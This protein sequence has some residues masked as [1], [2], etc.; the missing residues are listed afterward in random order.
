MQTAQIGSSTSLT[1]Q[2][3]ELTTFNNR[4]A[5]YRMQ[6]L[7]TANE[8]SAAG[9]SAGLIKSVAFD[10]SSVGD[11]ATNANFT[12]KIGTTALSALTDYVSSTGFTTVFPAATYTHAIGQNTIT[13]STPF[14]WNGTSNIIVEV[15]HSGI[16]AT[17]NA[18]SY[19]TSTTG[20]TV[21]YGFN[22]A[23]TG[24]LSTN[25]FNTTFVVDA[26][27]AATAY[28]WSDG[29]TTVG[30]SNPL[31]VVPTSTTSY[32]ATATANGCPI[33]SNT[34]TVTVNTL[35]AGPSATNS[36]QCGTQVPL[37]SVA[38]TAGAAGTGTFNWYA[39][40]TGGAALQSG[41][42][43]TYSTAVASTTTFYVSE[44]GTNGCESIRT[45]VT[46]T[47]GS[48]PVVAVTGPQTVCNNGIAQLNVTSTISDFDSYVWSPVANLF[49]DAAATVPYTG[50]SATTVYV[51]SAN[52]GA[53][54]FTVS[55]SNSI[56]SCANVASSTV[57]VLPATISATAAGSSF[58]LTGSTVL[59]ASPSTGLG[60]ATL[61]WQ[62]SSDNSTFTDL[63]GQTAATY[64]T[65]VLTSTT[66]YQVQIKNG[67]SVCVTSPSVAVIINNP[68]IVSTAPAAR[69]GTGTV[70]LGA[71]GSAGTTLNWYAAST[72]GAPLATGNSFTTPS[73]SASANYYVSAEISGNGAATV[74]AG[75]STTV[76]SGFSDD[77]ISPFG[78]YFGGMKG[79]FLIK[80][81][82]LYAAGLRAGNITSVTFDVVSGG[83][84]YKG[85]NMSIGSTALNA[86]TTTPVGGLTN[87]YSTTSPAGLTTPASGP[88]AINFSA[89]Y[90]WD[91]TSNIV[92]ETCWSNN[93]TGGTGT[94]V[95]YDATSYVSRNYYRDDSETPATIC[96]ATTMDGTLSSRP[97]MTFAGIAATC[98][99]S[100]STVTATVN[101]AP[102]ITVS[103]TPATICAGES[104]VLNVTSANSGYTYTWTPGSL[105]GASQ[106][107]SP[108]GTATYSVSASDNSGGANDGCTADGTVTVNV[109]PL[110]S[111]TTAT[112]TP[113]TICSGGSSQL[114]V[115]GYTPR[116]YCTPAMTSASATGDYIKSFTFG[117]ISNLNTPDAASDYT[118]YSG[119][120]ANVTAG[121]PVN[122][123][124]M[125]G[126]TSSTYA[127]QFRIWIDLNQ[128]GTFEATESVFNT[129][130]A[131]YSPTV[132]SGS[133]TIPV[134]AYNGITR[135]RVE[136]RYNTTPGTGEGCAGGSQWGE[137]ED[138]NVN[139][140]GGTS[141]PGFTYSWTPA[142]FLSDASIANPMATNATGT[143][144]YTVSVTASG[145]S[146]TQTIT[147]NV[148]PL[149]AINVASDD[150]DN[151]VCAG[152]S[153]M[154]T[155]SG[156]DTYVWSDGV[157]NATAFTPS[158]THTYTVTGTD[159]N[160]C[161]NTATATV[162]V[163][164]LPTVMA[165]SDD[166]NNA[167]CV[168]SSV[169]L[170]GMGATTYSWTSGFTNGI[171]NGIAFNP[172]AT[173][174]YTV[175]GTD[176]NGCT[177]TSSVT[178][179]VN[180]L[181]TVMAMSDDAN[182]AICIGSSLSLTGMGATSYDWTSG[183]TSG[184]TDGTAFT[185]S[186]TD[187]YTVTGTDA[188]GCTNTSTITV[189]VNALPA[190]TA[191]SD[192]AD[193]TICSGANVTLTGM[194]ASS[195]TWTGATAV[196]DNSPFTP[197]ATDT[198][199]VTGTDANGCMNTATITVTVN[200]A[201]T[202]TASSDDADNTVCAGTS[203]TLTGGG[204][205][206][207][208]WTGAT[209]VTNNTPFTPTATD[210]YTV[211]GTAANSCTNT[212]TI[213]ITVNSVPVVSLGADLTQCGSVILDAQNV[214]STYMWSDM[215]TAQTLNVT[216]SGTYFVTVN[217]GSC[218]ATDTINVTL[219]ALPSVTMTPFGA[220]V[221]DNGGPITLSGGLPAGGVY[222]G[223]SVTGGMFDPTGLAGAYL[224]T[225]I[226]TDS[227]TCT[228][229]DTATIMVDV[230]NGIAS[231]VSSDMNISVYP[232]PTDGIFTINITNAKFTKFSVSI[233]DIQGKEVYKDV[234]K[235]SST[236]YSKQ[237]DLEGFAKGVYY[238][239]MYTDSN[240]KIDKLVIH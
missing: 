160:G 216:S 198:Y 97:K 91:G 206:S 212:A 197:S 38:S 220:P 125:A 189:T 120:T 123:T 239:K 105:V 199:T 196:T 85:F 81:S 218:S 170:S 72:G 167:I 77:K 89:P 180:A 10:I 100:R 5:S 192:D 52:A 209:A 99:S 219:H 237:I 36:S 71:T 12:V 224:I 233:V 90:N 163:N 175:T 172:S 62:S 152:T 102:V 113:S 138:Y 127:E 54:T 19:Y 107:V 221:C 67:T 21:A 94:T 68:T 50:T 232:N 55:A 168:G 161:T 213:M 78:H 162:T 31:S 41:T 174:T 178:V 121:N 222:S 39:A 234:E 230:C 131:T 65:P 210:T 157:I 208:T 147:L 93:N 139:I 111:L 27:P 2:T 57:T 86:L 26:T 58:C 3:G 53:S 227:N 64:T 225:Y 238:I 150:A 151:T 143:T 32:V 103:A 191:M 165:M 156:A 126:G 76:S 66:Y 133:A 128:N 75:A 51:S 61:Q 203:V 87:V 20:N 40:S 185:P 204:A 9:L 217:N 45:P 17:N 96:G 43:T 1:T 29:S 164:P 194:G 211:T 33:T 166:A 144:T 4:R 11:A 79:Q 188:N 179:T 112:A 228:N 37:A 73:I 106:T 109:T 135:M 171:T 231:A 116:T 187:T 108:S 48:A 158:S 70:A 122:L 8:L 141:N 181:P 69:C 193:N 110:P 101:T 137:Y 184:I 47:V 34:V 169:T 176:A 142:T 13:F 115:A 92:I 205:V 190:V 201:P 23:T 28:S 240:L 145:C 236:V 202:V 207:Y 124:L 154:L 84:L 14:T 159:L 63:T 146:A 130:T 95:R 88:L 44:T 60:A 18:Q 82:E 80:A 153:V 134:T 136:A 24:T 46:V 223:A 7:F 15:S 42:S 22:G 235:N 56:T 59:T 49:T 140:S 117:N 149:P 83:T 6:L 155:A 182:N 98:V 200:T 195:Y 16:D 173:D 148:N 25:R 30:T 177:N 119:L 214:G 132:V 35:P 114:D 129:T 118:Y 226:V 229:S 215:S 74:G 104:T 186:A 183:L